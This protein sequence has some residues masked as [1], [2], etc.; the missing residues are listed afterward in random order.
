MGL[1]R[2]AVIVGAV[3]ALMPTDRAQQARLAEQATAAAKWTATFCER[4]AATCVQA[5]EVWGVF[6]RKA[7]FAGHLAYDLLQERLNGHGDP[8]ARDA[9]APRDASTDRAPPRVE[10]GTLTPHDLKPTWR[11]SAP[12][13]GA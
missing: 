7:E 4:N 9:T 13:Q 2:N 6:V 10:R 5:T 1:L 12:R 3:V 8:T 11:G